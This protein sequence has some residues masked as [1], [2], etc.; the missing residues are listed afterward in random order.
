MIE[1]NV[2]IEF[3]V[4]NHAITYIFAYGSPNGNDFTNR[5]IVDLDN[6]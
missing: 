3:N 2:A 1:N 5:F 4:E 6:T